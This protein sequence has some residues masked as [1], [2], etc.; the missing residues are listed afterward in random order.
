[1]RM[2]TYKEEREDAIH[3]WSEWLEKQ[4][5][6]LRALEPVGEGID[7]SPKSLSQSIDS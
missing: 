6:S 1:M 2:L 3:T 5:Q 4:H 7:A